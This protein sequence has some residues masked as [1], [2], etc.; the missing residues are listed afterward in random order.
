MAHLAEEVD[1]YCVN[2]E[3]VSFFRR[4]RNSLPSKRDG[5][6]MGNKML[7]MVPGFAVIFPGAKFNNC[8][9]RTSYKVSST[10]VEINSIKSDVFPVKLE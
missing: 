2:T 3:T 1:K 10:S 9:E 5:L 6:Y 7:K 4:Q 8:S